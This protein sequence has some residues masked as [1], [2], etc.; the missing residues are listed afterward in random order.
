MFRKSTLFVFV[1]L[2]LVVAPLTL[3]QDTFGLSTEDYA[4]LTSQ[5]MD[6]TSISFDLAMSLSITGSPDGDVLVDLNGSGVFGDGA[7]GSPVG[8]F[9][10]TGAANAGGET[11]PVDFQMRIVDN[12]L[13]MN[14]GDGSGWRGQSLDDAM[15]T[16]GS[17]API[18]VNPMDL[19]SGNMADNPQAMEAMGEMMSALEGFDPSTLISMSRLDDMGGQAHFRIDMDLQSFLSS[20]AFTKM[21]GAAGTMSGDESMAGMGAMLGMMFQDMS[22]SLDEFIELETNRARQA[23][24]NFGMGIDPSVMGAED[25]GPMNIGFMLDISNLQYDVPVDVSV[26]EGA[27]IMPSVAG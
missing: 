6:S 27:T 17:M 8:S 14:L 18:P 25:A 3:A 11:I 10:L 19:A 21:M 26:P 20:E 5:D 15:S 9:N 24:L 23:I 16:F 7:G 13:Y 12:M 2:M 22:L 1:L 4:L